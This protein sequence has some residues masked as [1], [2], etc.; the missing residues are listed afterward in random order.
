MPPE[1]PDIHLPGPSFWPIVMAGGVMMIAAGVLLTP[2]I[3]GLGLVVVLTCIAG[4]T[5][6]NRLEAPPDDDEE[7]AHV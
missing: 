4:W 6:E 1:T 2:V 7:E 5:Q 3:S